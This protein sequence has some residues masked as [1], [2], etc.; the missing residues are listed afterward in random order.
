[1][2]ILLSSFNSVKNV[3]QA[4]FISCEL[5]SICNNKGHNCSSL[6]TTPPNVCNS[7]LTKNIYM[8][9]RIKIYC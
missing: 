4:C 9:R 2:L 5:T 3:F 8:L 1:M 7:V 6:A